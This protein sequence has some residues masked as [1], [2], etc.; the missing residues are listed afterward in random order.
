MS[1]KPPLN[2]EEK[3]KQLLIPPGLYIRYLYQKQLR[4]GEA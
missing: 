3:L 2:L 4:S 1:W